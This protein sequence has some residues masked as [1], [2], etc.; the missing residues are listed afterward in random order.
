MQWCYWWCHQCHTMPTL[1][2]HDEKKLCYTSFQISWYN[3]QYGAIDN[4]ISV[5]M[6]ALM[7]TAS[8]DK[9]SHVTPC[10]NFHHL[11]NKMVPL[12]MHLALYDSNAGTNV[13]TWLKMS[14]FTSFWSLWPNEWNGA[15]DNTIGTTKKCLD[16][17][18]HVQTQKD[19][20]SHCVDISR[21][22][23]DM[24]IYLDMS[25]HINFF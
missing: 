21:H 3:E 24:E 4:G 10:S 8:H 13:I 1:V 22:C 18:R 15:I 5:F 12:M 14:Y 6:L 20:S 16:I 7:S 11:I 9:N 25:R 23:L 2:S 19:M 17:F